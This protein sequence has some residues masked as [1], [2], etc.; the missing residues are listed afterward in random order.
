MRQRGFLSLHKASNR[1]ISPENKLFKKRYR[2]GVIKCALA[3]GPLN[4]L[5]TMLD[6]AEQLGGILGM[7]YVI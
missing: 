3:D 6:K 2:Y 1:Y 4:I 5:F 7:F